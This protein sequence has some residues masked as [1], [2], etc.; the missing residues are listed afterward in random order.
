MVLPANTII[1]FIPSMT[2]FQNEGKDSKALTILYEHEFNDRF[3]K[4]WLKDLKAGYTI[5]FKMELNEQ[6]CSFAHMWYEFFT[7]F[8]K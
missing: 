7:W 8:I 6:Y 4:K 2:L 1:Y 3:W 5:F